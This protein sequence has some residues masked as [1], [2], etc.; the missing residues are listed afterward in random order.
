[1]RLRL[2]TLA[3]IASLFFTSA[4]AQSISGR[5][6][7][8]KGQLLPYVALAL[9]QLPD[10]S[11]LQQTSSDEQG[12]FRFEGL[13]AGHYL[14][15]ASMLGFAPT[16]TTTLELSA[17]IPKL[18]DLQ[19]QLIEVVAQLQTATISA[20][21]PLIEMKDN[22]LVVNIANSSLAEGNN[23]LEI[24]A[25]SPGVNVDNEGTIFLKGKASVRVFMDGKPLYL[26][27]PDLAAFLRG[28]PSNQLE[29]L[30]IMSN[31]P[32]QYDAEGNAGVINIRSK[33]NQNYG[34]N[35]SVN[36]SL[37]HGRLPKH[38]SGF[39]V[40]SRGA[41]TN[42]WANYA[43][44]YREDFT[45]SR[46]Q[47]LFQQ[48]GQSFEQDLRSEYPNWIHNLRSGLDVELNKRNS[49]GLV[50]GVNS[51]VYKTLAQNTSNF[52][53]KSKVREARTVTNTNNRVLN[54]N[55]A[56]SLNYRHQFKHEG[57][58]LSFDAD[59][60]VFSLNDEQN[61]NS[62]F[63]NFNNNL[64]A[65]GDL[66]TGDIGADI[67]I[68]ALKSD[69]VHPFS[70]TL[71]LETGLK[72]SFVETANDVV[73][74][75]NNTLDTG[76]TNNF[77]YQEN[78]N[79]AYFN[80]A[81]T[82]NK[83]RLNLGLRAEQTLAEGYQ[84]VNDSGFVRNYWNLFPNL[85]IK[86]SLPQQHEL[87]LSFSR[88]ID[89]PNYQDLNPFLFFFDN[90]TYVLG[91][92]FLQPQLSTLFELNYVHPK[93]L[94]L[95]FNYSHTTGV[96]TRVLQQ[97]DALQTIFQ[98]VLNLNTFKNYGLALNFPYKFATFWQSN[99]SLNI[100]RNHYYG[101][102]LNAAFDQRRTSLGFNS[103][104]NL[105][106]GKGWTAELNLIYQSRVAYGIFLYVPSGTV[107]LGIQKSIL[108]QYGSLR[109]SVRDILYTQR[110]GADIVYQNM[111]IRVRHLVDSRFVTLAFNYRFGN[112]KVAPAKLRKTASEEE[113][114][115]TGQ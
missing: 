115:R 90:Y 4:H 23:A 42:F 65:K 109:L 92:S 39:T 70:K 108:Q 73:F 14:I 64:P 88:R 91:N 16:Q 93:N 32:A 77:R 13:K 72:T 12:A 68:V 97:D 100:F 5:T 1:M 7:D 57:S 75:Y 61:Y 54:Q 20:Q 74:R 95:T 67:R 82:L 101:T 18:N 35:G 47:R 111:D 86:Q 113:R 114:R 56:G 46:T 27:G 2:F 81:K 103:I 36:F 78:I 40:N 52:L 110:R 105:N 44:T 45:D 3:F 43:F 22:K 58:S 41:K 63:E 94:V 84:V 11:L 53:D 99:N 55:A 15:R 9:Y 21:R 38:N 107:S 89:R 17:A 87:S 80:L 60:S 30:E 50:A 31:P 37:G 69:F 48:T 112:Q 98:T 34:T 24:L 29:N 51:L 104:H 71:L 106:F 6:S 76:K 66:L 83:T 85:S 59:Y 28:L 96:M 79:A 19:V 25:R 8:R 102:Y 33:K 26:S 49:I 62:Y 10:S